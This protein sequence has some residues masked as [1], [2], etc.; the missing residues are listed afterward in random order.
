MPEFQGAEAVTVPKGLGE[1]AGTVRDMVLGMTTK[2]R[3]SLTADEQRLA[4][5]LR[6]NEDLFE[7]LKSIIQSRIEGRAR[8]KEPS[9]PL[10]CKSMLARDRELRSLLNRLE[11]VYRSPVS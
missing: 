5:H 1:A 6:G 2:M 3:Q 11:F 9:D 7:G 10:I 8:L 4:A